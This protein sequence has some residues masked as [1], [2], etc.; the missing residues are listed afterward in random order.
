MLFRYTSS[1]SAVFEKASVTREPQ[2]TIVRR[3]GSGRLY[4]IELSTDS[5]RSSENYDARVVQMAAI[6]RTLGVCRGS[7]REDVL[8][9]AAALID[10]AMPCA[11][12]KAA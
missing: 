11:V 10:A 1:A 3:A 9:K 2:E 7:T 5:N 6:N 12:P 4:T 8:R